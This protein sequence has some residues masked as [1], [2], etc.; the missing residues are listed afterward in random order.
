MN[1]LTDVL[2][3]LK[4]KQFIDVAGEEDVLVL[5][6]HEPPEITGVASPIPYKN[7][8]LIKIKD[9]VDLNKCVHQNLPTGD[10]PYA[11]V[12]KDETVDIT[13]ECFIN[14]RRLKS[15]SLNLTI[16]ENG[17]F[18]DFVN[19]AEANT[20]ANVGTGAQIYKEKIGEEFKLRTLVS[21]DASITITQNVDEIDF[22]VNSAPCCELSD[23]L[24]VGNTMLGAQTIN[25]A[26]GN[27][28]FSLS[29][30][31]VAD[32][33][34]IDNDS[35]SYGQGWF[36]LEGNRMQVGYSDNYY[37]AEGNNLRMRL[38]SPA[39]DRYL[40]GDADEIQLGENIPLNTD[41]NPFKVFRT[42]G[43]AVTLASSGG[44]KVVALNNAVITANLNVDCVVA[45]AASGGTLKT[46]H[47]AY[48]TQAGFIG[49]GDAFEGLLVRD[50]LTADRTYTLQ[51]GDGTIA[52]L[53]DI[54]DLTFQTLVS[55][56]TAWDIAN[57]VN[58]E[59]TLT[60]ASIL[61][62]TGVQ[63]GD[64][65]TLIVRQDAVGGHTLGLPAN[66]KVVNGGGGAITLSAGA[67]E[68]DII[69][70][71]YDGT[72]FFISYGLNFT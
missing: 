71:V 1:I 17:D 58:A 67:N 34:Q 40:S 35:G 41:T 56:V 65:G 33:I 66:F 16:T 5:G 64:Y 19:L 13:G 7:V 57:G 47:T 30:G 24:A 48:L 61:S 53:S 25:A 51:D 52:F 4:R 20:I 27:G 14:L 3:L 38:G 31:G 9:F 72:D 42:D 54:T 12:F 45:L 10:S 59:V 70:W 2:G 60:G 8:K 11:G 63:D 39:A 22:V 43:G 49:S 26:V 23:V 69:S 46:D 36:Y 44:N 32:V 6:I 68:E 18:I 21:S 28:Q 29:V 62:V 37:E 55:G 15:L 50:T